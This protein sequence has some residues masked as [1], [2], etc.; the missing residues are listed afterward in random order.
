MPIPTEALELENQYLRLEAGEKSTLA[1]AY[2]ILKD[3]NFLITPIL[4][5]RI[6]NSNKMLLESFKNITTYNGTDDTNDNNNTND[7][8]RTVFLFTLPL[9]NHQ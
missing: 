8:K 3:Y 4:S 9:T 5:N 1:A 2:K 7:S 6:S